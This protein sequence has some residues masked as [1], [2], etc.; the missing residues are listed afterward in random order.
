M[1]V[2]KLYIDLDAVRY[3]LKAIQDRVADKEVMAIVKADAYG[4][5]ALAVAEALE[6]H[7]W[8][9]GV[10]GAEEALSLRGAGIKKPILV[11]GYILPDYIPLLI[12]KDIQMTLYDLE[13]AETL[14][15]MAAQVNARATVHLKINTGHNRLG[16]RPEDIETMVEAYHLDHL[17]PIGIFSHYAAA[18]DASEKAI[19]YTKMQARLFETAVQSLK[20]KG[21][22]FQWVHLANDPGLLTYPD[23]GNL[24]RSGICLY[25]VYPSEDVRMKEEG[26]LK[27]VATLE[28]QVSFLHTIYPGESVSYNNTFSASQEMLIATVSAGYADGVPRL[29]SNHGAVMIRGQEA[30]IVGR[31][32]MDQFMVDVTNIPGVKKGDAVRI[33]G[34][35]GIDIDRFAAWAQTNAYEILTGVRPRV[36]RVYLEDK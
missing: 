1:S 3:N 26:L 5:G 2:N 12:Q 14:N 7:V 10:A 16:F 21:C 9:F 32:C 4:T 28:S 34:K 27:T 24:V 19:A 15:Q 25:G 33:F 29:L 6:A 18:D 23:S 13:G 36:E 11:M 8:G 35:E 30:P 20:E 17:N 31:V 22:D